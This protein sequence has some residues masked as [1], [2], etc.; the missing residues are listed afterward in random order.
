MA[1]RKR[2][3][4]NND[5]QNITRKTKD[6][7]T[8]TPLKIGGEF[9][10]SGRVSSS[11]STCDSITKHS[12]GVL[13]WRQ[14]IKYVTP[15]KKYKKPAILPSPL[16]FY[17]SFNICMIRK[18]II[19]FKLMIMQNNLYFLTVVSFHS[20][21]EGFISTILENCRLDRMVVWYTACHH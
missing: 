18:N 15:Y 4:T 16:A 13:K 1:I 10:A 20:K 9:R 21:N 12:R 19:I 7:T 3:R 17:N 14:S 8:R 5:L 2:T 6:R 11:C